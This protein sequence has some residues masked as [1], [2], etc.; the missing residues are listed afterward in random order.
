MTCAFFCGIKAMRSDGA[1]YDYHDH[2]DAINASAK[3]EAEE[4]TSLLSSK[5]PQVLDMLIMVVPVLVMCVC[6]TLIYCRLRT[7]DKS[8]KQL[9]VVAFNKRDREVRQRV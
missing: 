7:S 2:T 3:R 5:I 1:R 9:G 4:K 6:Y 8:L